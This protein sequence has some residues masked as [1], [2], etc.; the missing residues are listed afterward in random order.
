MY[1][2]TLGRSPFSHTATDMGQSLTGFTDMKKD[3]EPKISCFSKDNMAQR[4]RAP[5]TDVSDL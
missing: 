1:I 4:V 2:S 5:I 3:F